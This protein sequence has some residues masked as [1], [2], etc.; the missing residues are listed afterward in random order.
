MKNF[1]QLKKNTKKIS[2]HL[3]KI[4]IIAATVIF[5]YKFFFKGLLPIPS[6]ITTGIY[7]P[8]LDYK[9]GNIVGVG[10]KNNIMSDIPSLIYPWRT[11][12][13]EY[14]KHFQ[15]PL[16]NPFS[17][18]GYPLLANWQSAPFSI[19]NLFFL[20][21]SNPIAWSLGVVSQPLLATTF[22]YY[23]LK[24]KNLN[25]IPALTG[26]LLFAYSGFHITWQYYNTHQWVTLWLPLMLLSIDHLIKSAK[27]NKST[28]SNLL[29]SKWTLILSLSISLSIL[30]G[31][32]ILLIYQGI[33]IGLYLLSQLS[34]INR[35]KIL[36]VGLLLVSTA[37]LGLGLSAPQ[38]LP[39]L[40][41]EKQ[42]IHQFDNSTLDSANQGLLPYQNL[43]TFI[44]PDYFGNPTTQNYWGIGYYDNWALYITIAGLTLSL[45]GIVYIRQTYIWSITLIIGLIISTNN[46]AGKYLI[47]NI[48][49]LRNS[50]PARGIYLIDTMI[51][52]LA[53]YGLHHFNQPKQNLSTKIKY[54][55]P[56]IAII[57]GL[58]AILYLT[59]IKS[60]LINNLSANN[61]VGIRNLIFPS[62]LIFSTIT[63]WLINYKFHR[64]SKYVSIIILI[65]VMTDIFR[66]GQKYLPFTPSQYVFPKTDITQWLQ[67]HQN[68]QDPHRIEFGKVIPQNMWIPYRLSSPGGYDALAPLRYNQFLT[69]IQGNQINSSITRFPTIENLSSPL[70][71]LTNTKYILA[72]K[73]NQN[74]ER[75]PEGSYLIDSTYDLPFLKPI[76]EYGTVT[77]LE[78]QHYLPRAFVVPHAQTIED[79]NQLISI[80]T[81]PSTDYLQTVYL[82]PS[83]SNRLTP[84]TNKPK[85]LQY[86]IKWNYNYGNIRNLTINTDQPGY[87]VLLE[88]Y[89]QDWHAVISNSNGIRKSSQS[90]K[91]YTRVQ[92]KPTR[93]NFNFMA[94]SIPSGKNQIELKYQPKE[95]IYGLYIWFASLITWIG[96]FII[97]LKK[98][99]T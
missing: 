80:L 59:F 44:A 14:L 58:M 8:W 51:A 65:L 73:Y 94:I 11:L 42:S 20:I 7:Y 41:Y 60:N 25:T 89:N 77:V 1:Q 31:Y 87:L 64:Y 96:L 81:D 4:A 78:N 72:L 62:A 92:I 13:I 67:T 95:F 88:P 52:I 76:Y 36:P 74:W 15:W 75:T 83:N 34:S 10:V 16:W 19:S 43:I 56:P 79:D 63:L 99:K 17:F 2:Q 55:L 90:D 48:P 27:S 9:W 6:D 21:F 5:Y 28:F 3:P 68:P 91:A 47:D 82:D 98:T 40:Q 46:P 32:P 71:Q 54:F 29:I 37:I 23:W 84:N 97:S 50:I 49:F 26:G 86:T 18:S 61:I 66:Y 53:A 22:M 24:T 33:I 93:A 45:L 70:F 69:A 35:H 12:A 30:A 39:A 85:Q 57:L 38:W